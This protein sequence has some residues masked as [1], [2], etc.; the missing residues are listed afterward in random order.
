M[1]RVR[2]IVAHASTLGP[3]APDR[4][5]GSQLGMSAVL[6]TR[7]GYA[8]QASSSVSNTGMSLPK[9]RARWLCSFF[10]EGVSSAA[11]IA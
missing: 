4:Q 3:Q 6:S 11:E 1:R 9:A 10:T 5:F 2:V 8:G 7:D